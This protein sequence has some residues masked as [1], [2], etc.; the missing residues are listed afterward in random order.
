MESV[1]WGIIGCGN[2]T[3]VKSGPAFSKVPY[4]RLV[5]V[6]RRN[7]QKA[8]DYAA[9][10]GVPKWYD[11]ALELVNDPEVNAIYVATPPSSHEEYALMAMEAGKQV[12]IEKPMS[13]S[14][15]S[16]KRIEEKAKQTGIKI[17]I[18]H[19]R[20]EQPLFQ[21]IKQL[22]EDKAIGKIGLASLQ[23]YQPDQSD[24]VAV[25]EENWRLDP[26]V[27]GGGLFHDLAPHQLDIMTWLFGKVLSATG[28]SLNTGGLYKVDDTVSGQVLFN[29]SVLFT[30]SWCFTAPL[31]RDVC[32][33]H[34]T[35]GIIR[36]SIFE[37]NPLVV[38][39]DGVEETYHFDPLPHVQQPM[40]SKVVEYFLGKSGNPCS[41]SEGVQVMQIMDSFTGKLKTER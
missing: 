14:A 6:M 7:G 11:S 34:G 27:S 17:S 39:K 22:V 10:H 29:D 37:Q 28:L 18:A 3:E 32:E 25:T 36:F 15:A 35:H 33:L 12:Y 41:A 1:N 31:K 21:K 4:S 16:A 26:E 8:K 13:P 24:L 23:F 38:L 19:Y 9:R 20:R 5:A 2:V 30:G 40:I